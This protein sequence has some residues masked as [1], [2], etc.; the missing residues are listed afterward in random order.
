MATVLHLTA[1]GLART[2]LRVAPTLSMATTKEVP[3]QIQPFCLLHFRYPKKM[4]CTFEL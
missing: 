2:A 3:K 1:H 4:V